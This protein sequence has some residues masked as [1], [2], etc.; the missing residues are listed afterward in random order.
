MYKS[1][2][3]VN[4][5][6]ACFFVLFYYGIPTTTLLP[7]TL[8]PLLSEYPLWSFENFSLNSDAYA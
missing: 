2:R 6:D 5:L 3:E 4:L 7:A 8:L 1:S